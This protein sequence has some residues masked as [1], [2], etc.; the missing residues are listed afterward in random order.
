VL[1]EVKARQ[2][3]E[4]AARQAERLKLAKAMAEGKGPKLPAV[5]PGAAAPRGR[6]LLQAS[7]WGLARRD[8]LHA[9][10]ARGRRSRKSKSPHAGRDGR[11]R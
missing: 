2:A 6:V 8:A 10:R 7:P 5:G 3:A 1:P 11:G 9:M 4:E